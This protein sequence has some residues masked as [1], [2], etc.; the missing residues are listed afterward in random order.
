MA[1]IRFQAESLQAASRDGSRIAPLRAKL[2]A[3]IAE[4]HNDANDL[5]AA[6]RIA[7]TAFLIRVGG[8]ALAY[9]TQIALARWMGAPEFGL[10]IY[11]WTWVL[12]AGDLIHLGLA[13]AATRLIPQ[14]TSLG[15]TDRLQGFIIGSQWLV[16][17][18]STLLAAGALALVYVGI[19]GDEHRLLILLACVSLPFHALAN[20]LDGLARSYNLIN[21]ALVPPYFVRP[22]ILVSLVAVLYAIGWTTSAVV[23]MGAAAVAGLIAIAVQGID[24]NR[25]IA[26]VIGKVRPRYVLRE[27]FTTSWPLF[28][29]ISFYTLFTYT[30]ILVLKYF[31]PAEDI[32][33]YFAATKTLAL[34]TFIS[35]SV[36]AAVG[37]KFAEYHVAERHDELAELLA[38]ST[39]WT[40]WPSL[41]ATLFVLAIGQPILHL[42]G[43]NFVSA[44]PLMFVSAIGLLA[45]AVVGPAERLLSMMGQQHACAA[46]YAL[47]F[48]VA[49]L[50]CVL[51]IPPFG[52][53]G[54]AMA[55][56][57][58]LICESVLLFLVIK[59]RT[60][61]HALVWPVR[62]AANKTSGPGETP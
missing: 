8:A 51:L 40:F 9:L 62:S 58:A 30:D 47:T 43:K 5:S 31:R 55:M 50:A 36:S 28:L 7:G 32:A 11:A 45:R 20:M 23:A 54:A 57:G 33:L 49:L 41:A 6:R 46:I 26:A 22:L 39:A 60:G 44:Y 3:A 15:Q 21:S 42:F 24:V 38:Q 59:R 29:L 10:F 13:S 56:T 27:W 53:M 12:L 17:V 37:H 25:R 1:D 14:Y 52:T 18:L 35:F 48:A 61:L 19:L 34:V 4:I 2:S 16:L